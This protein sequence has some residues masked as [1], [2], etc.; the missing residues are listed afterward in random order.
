M[1][2][3]QE[4][5]RFPSPPHTYHSVAFIHIG[6]RLLKL[7]NLRLCAVAV[8]QLRGGGRLLSAVLVNVRLETF[9]DRQ[10]LLLT[11]RDVVR[12]SQCLSLLLQ[13]V[14]S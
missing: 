13:N 2:R 5:R 11:I 10:Q 7:T 8:C 1:K 4:T 12:R 6:V 14:R 3:S 9:R